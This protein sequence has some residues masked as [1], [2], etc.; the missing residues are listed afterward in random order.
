MAQRRERILFV[1]TSHDT[2]GD[3][4][5]PTGFHFDE[6][7]APYWSFADAGYE[8]EIA[9]VAGGRPPHDPSSLPEEAEK[10]SGSLQRFLDDSA[11]MAKLESTSAVA[12]VTA[13]DY[14]AIYLPG[15]HGTM[16]D[17]PDNE[18]LGQLLL[19]AADNG[20]AIGAV[21]HGPA[22]LFAARRGEGYPL[23]AGRRLN[24]FTDE[25]ERRV[26]LTK[27]VPFLLESRLKEVGAR[28][29]KSSAFRACVVRDGMLVTGQNP[30]SARAVAD[31]MLEIMQDG[32]TENAA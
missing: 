24:A 25:E 8:V 14:A 10:R 16:W 9:S 11:A 30:R 12:S 17:L 21:C 31:K 22:G 6:L 29:E 27:V 15:G 13:G 28:F 1:L 2:L 7:A 19:T 20:A 5:K 26:H 32:C 18:A 23:I 4:D 3:T